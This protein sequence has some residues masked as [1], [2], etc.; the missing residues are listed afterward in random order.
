MLEIIQAGYAET[1]QRATNLGGVDLVLTSPPYMDA[2][3][4]GAGVSWKFEDYQQLGDAVFLALKPGGHCLMVLDGPVREWR[5][6]YGT[7]R[8][9][10]AWEVMLDWAKR[11]GFRAPDRLAYGRRG[12]P[13]AYTGRFKNDWEPL[14]WFQRPG[15]AG[16]FDKWPLA[17]ETEPYTN[18]LAVCTGT[19]RKHTRNATG[20]AAT[21]GL[22]HRGTLWWYGSTGSGNDRSGEETEHP[23]RFYSGFAE[24]VV[25]CFCPPDGLVCDP[26][27]GSGTS[28]AAALKHGRRF[29]GGDLL[30]RPQD[31]KSWASIAEERAKS[32]NQQRFYEC[33][34][35]ESSFTSNQIEKGLLPPHTFLGRVC[36]NRKPR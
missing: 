16:Y 32:I 30:N 1:L 29:I 15:A 20:R 4:Y 9:F 27:V 33:P 7:E 10:I 6:G 28:A 12:S 36:E 31:G 13:G 35:C 22:S 19:D 25:Q 3:T 2:R 24:D 21:E 18:K 17:S 14:L 26:F 23:A 11:V 8:S 5:K 34:D